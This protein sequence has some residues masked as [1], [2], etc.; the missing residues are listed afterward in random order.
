MKH[1]DF[2]SGIESMLIPYWFPIDSALAA[3][4]AVAELLPWSGDQEP[5]MEM[6]AVD[7]G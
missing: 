4:A 2:I 5:R 6:M 3:A 1:R 7:G